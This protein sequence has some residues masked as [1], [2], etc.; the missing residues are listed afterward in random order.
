MI[1]DWQ[2]HSDQA[3]I[4]R[5]R[6]LGL[7]TGLRSDKAGGFRPANFERGLV[8]Q[9]LVS[10]CQPATVLELGTGRGLGS[11]SIADAAQMQGLHCEITSV[12]IVPP[13][14]PQAWAIERN[15]EQ[16]DIQASV[17]EIWERHVHAD[18]RR[19]VKL[20]TGRTTDV[21]PRLA[22]EKRKF[23]LIFIDAGHDL[24]SVIHDLAYAA[25]LVEEDGGIL[26]DDFAPQEAFGLGTCVALPHARRLFEHVE[27]FP[28]EGLVYGGAVYPDAPRGMVF[29]QKPRQAALTLNRSRLLWW[30]FASVVLERCGRA[31]LFPLT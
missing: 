4:E 3:R 10:L 28:T 22:A 27:V 30:K 19:M 8:L 17:E 23:D 7:L 9:R 5:V 13:N 2:Q 14:T 16:A 11:L 18:L 24:Y 6:R 29:L 15:G 21:L 31:D 1:S 26:M 25:L 12:D 20:V